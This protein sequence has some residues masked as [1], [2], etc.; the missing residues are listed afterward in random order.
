MHS[1]YHYCVTY[2]GSEW[3]SNKKERV[4]HKYGTSQGIS[5]YFRVNR[6]SPACKSQ[7]RTKSCILQTMNPLTGQEACDDH[8][9]NMFEQKRQLTWGLDLKC[10]LL[11]PSLTSYSIDDCPLV[12]SKEWV[13][14]PSF[15]NTIIGHVS[16]Q[17]KSEEMGGEER[18]NVSNDSTFPCLTN[19]LCV[20]WESSVWSRIEVKW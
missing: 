7:S 17:F 6:T 16:E 15:K 12:H 3:L 4:T 14:F 10:I 2:T 1:C 8:S 5:S 9:L 11:S 18:Q 20:E 13:T 19:V